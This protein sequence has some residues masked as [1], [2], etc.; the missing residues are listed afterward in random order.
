MISHCVP[1]STAAGQRAKGVLRPSRSAA[2]M[3]GQSSPMWQATPVPVT[4]TS[5]ARSLTSAPFWLAGPKGVRLMTAAILAGT[6][7]RGEHTG[8]THRQVC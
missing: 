7:G 8:G 4:T 2:S 1:C 6:D 3:A 5:R